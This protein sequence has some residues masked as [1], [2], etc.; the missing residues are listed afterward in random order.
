MWK[1]QQ[2]NGYRNINTSFKAT[3]TMCCCYTNN[4]LKATNMHELCVGCSWY[5]NTEIGRVCI[6]STKLSDIPITLLTI[7]S[8]DI[9]K[10]DY[11]ILDALIQY[12]IKSNTSVSLLTT[13]SIFLV[14]MKLSGLGLQ[15]FTLHFC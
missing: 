5:I 9:A 15:L 10:V 14:N 13:L 1:Q 2:R 4:D 6:K 8:G 12:S 7:L 11:I 3:D